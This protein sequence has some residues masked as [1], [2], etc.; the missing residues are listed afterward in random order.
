MPSFNM[1]YRSSKSR[2]DESSSSRRQPILILADRRPL[3]MSGSNLDM[4]R[5]G[6]ENQSIALY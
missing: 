1:E 2:N 6:Q 4:V 3:A 5:F